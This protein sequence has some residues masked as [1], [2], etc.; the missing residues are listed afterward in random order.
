MKTKVQIEERI[1]V[2]KAKLKRIYEFKTETP[3]QVIYENE[4]V[5]LEWVLR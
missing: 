2:L 3:F 4:I 5:V 1:K